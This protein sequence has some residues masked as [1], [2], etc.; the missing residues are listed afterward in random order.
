MAD[1]RAK[2]RHVVVLMLENRSF[3]NLLGGSIPAGPRST[4]SPAANEIPGATR[5]RE[6]CSRRSMHG[7]TQRACQR[8]WP[9]Q[10]PIPASGS[11]T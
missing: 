11:T 3:D 6:D 10:A 2:I 7:R 1:L 4:A 8:P 9:F 5:K